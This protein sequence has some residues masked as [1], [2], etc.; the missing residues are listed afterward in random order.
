MKT[1]VA[2]A[3]RPGQAE[4]IA[5]VAAFILSPASR[6]LYGTDIWVDGGMAAFATS[7]A[8]GLESVRNL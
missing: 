7:D 1:N 2:R 5:E 3:G 6:W 4:E 8:L